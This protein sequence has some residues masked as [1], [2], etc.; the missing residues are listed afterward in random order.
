M[1]LAPVT[2][3]EALSMLAELKTAKMFKGFRGAAPRDLQATAKAIATISQIGAALGEELLELDINPLFI[4]PE[5][6]GVKSW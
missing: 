4:L 2:E 5:G 6:E 3:A 1:R